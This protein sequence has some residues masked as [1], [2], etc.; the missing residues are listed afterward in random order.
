MRK[1]CHA[2][3]K[4]DCDHPYVPLLSAGR[5]SVFYFYYRMDDAETF[6]A[7][8][9][10]ILDAI[11]KSGAAMSHHHGIGKMFAPWLEGQLGRKEY[12]VFHALKDYFDPGL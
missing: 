3:A 7:Y 5:Q 11:Q 6:K 10:T 12:G 9:A 1:V 4:Y 8:H 2:P